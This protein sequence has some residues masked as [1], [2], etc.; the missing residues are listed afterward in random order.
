LEI[1]VRTVQTHRQ[2]IMTKLGLHSATALTRF[3]VTHGLA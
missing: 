2:S 1:S 3:A